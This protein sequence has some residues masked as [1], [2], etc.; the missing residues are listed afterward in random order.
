MDISYLGVTSDRVAT[1]TSTTTTTTPNHS[2][3]INPTHISI[4]NPT[5][6][7]QIA[8]AVARVTPTPLFRSIF[9]GECSDQSTAQNGKKSE[10][11]FRKLVCLHD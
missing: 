7:T 11:H 2:P 9:S 4:P 5:W 10:T 3:N 1:T 8:V 6:T